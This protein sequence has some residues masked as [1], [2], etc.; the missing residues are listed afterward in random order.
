MPAPVSEFHNSAMVMLAL[1]VEADESRARALAALLSEAGCRSERF[2]TVEATLPHLQHGAQAH[3]LVLLLDLDGAQAQQDLTLLRSFRCTH[4]LPPMLALAGAD[5]PPCQ[6][7]AWADGLAALL[8]RDAGAEALRRALRALRRLRS[9]DASAPSEDAQVRERLQGLG[10]GPGQFG[11]AL[12]LEQQG[13]H[14]LLLCA[15]AWLRGQGTEAAGLAL[16]LAGAAQS[17]GAARLA[18]RCHQLASLPKGEEL[19]LQ[20]GLLAALTRLELDRLV[21]LLGD[22]ALTPP[23]PTRTPGQRSAPGPQ[24]GRTSSA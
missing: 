10:G 14:L 7:E 16:R 6:A 5:A 9:A 4:T 8:P 15:Q 20:L 18:S 21:C 17:L 12:A 1:I 13:R 19:P 2:A 23:G 11:L 22:I 3:E 24:L